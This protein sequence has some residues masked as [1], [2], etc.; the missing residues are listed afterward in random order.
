MSAPP[1]VRAF[2]LARDGHQCRKCG[3]GQALHA[4]HIVPTWQGGSDDPANLVTLCAPCH[5]EW[6]MA[7][8]HLTIAFDRWLT[9]PP[10]RVLLAAYL[11][12]WPNTITTADVKDGIYLAHRALV[13]IEAPE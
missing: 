4:H 7:E 13:G 10:Y 8:A 6:H 11:A 5:A 1:A 2:V 9:V 3:R 12:E